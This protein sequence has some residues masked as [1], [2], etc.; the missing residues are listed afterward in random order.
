MALQV[1]FEQRGDISLPLFAPAGAKTSM[2]R[3]RGV[4][5]A[6]AAET[7]AVGKLPDY[8]TLQLHIEAA[9][10]AVAD[11]GPDA[12]ATSTASPPSTRRVRCRSRTRSASRR[13]WMD[14]TGVGRHL[15]PAA[16]P[17]RG[18]GDPGRLRDER[19]SSR[20]ANRAAPGSARSPFPRGA[21]SMPG[22]FEAPYG[23]AG[24]DHGLHHS[25][26]PVHEGVR[27]HPRAA[28]LRRGRAA[29]VGGAQ[30]AGD[31]PRPDHGRGR[32]GVPA[33]R[34]AVPPAGVLPGHRRRRRADRDRRPT[35]PPTSPSRPCTSSAPGSRWRRR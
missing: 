26:A 1:T 31:V 21:S 5:I 33:G 12:C 30:P 27:A 24:P 3:E 13:R 20:T 35:A 25:G 32:A 8:S 22:Q 14:G 28:R 18:G 16:C 7:D 19:S 29:E 10:N 2:S 34:L 6:G 15:V 11:A 9:V 17:A 23:T 4:I